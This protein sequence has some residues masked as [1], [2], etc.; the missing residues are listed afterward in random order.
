MLEIIL[1]NISLADFAEIVSS[2]DLSFT[3]HIKNFVWFDVFEVTDIFK[4]I[5]LV[6]P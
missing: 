6:T 1:S 4:T 5:F 2:L 3:K